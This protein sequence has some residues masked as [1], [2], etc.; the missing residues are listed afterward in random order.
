MQE[1]LRH[2][3]EGTHLNAVW[4]LVEQSLG[5]CRGRETDST[6]ATQFTKTG[7]EPEATANMQQAYQSA[8]LIFKTPGA[9]SIMQCNRCIIIYVRLLSY[10]KFTHMSLA[11]G[12]VSL[13][14]K[15]LIY[16]L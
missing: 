13:H 9:R 14:V 5:C 16:H 3:A 7:P 6:S 8:V 12:L 4:L 11:E 15:R 2:C 10:H 1:I